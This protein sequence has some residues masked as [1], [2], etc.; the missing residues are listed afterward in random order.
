MVPG[1]G[2][3]G[4]HGGEGEVGGMRRV[5][6]GL[7]RCPRRRRGSP[8]GTGHGRGSAGGGFVSGVLGW[9]GERREGR[10]EISKNWGWDSRAE[11]DPWGSNNGG[12]RGG[13]GGEEIEIINKRK[14]KKKSGR[15]AEREGEREKKTREREKEKRGNLVR[16]QMWR[17]APL[18][19]SSSYIFLSRSQLLIFTLFFLFHKNYRPS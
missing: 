8:R 3:G 5:H 16:I 12:G 9:K 7:R 19:P 10:K 18:P 13:G 4:P 1:L 17:E 15:R 14:K 2:E 6:G 11:G